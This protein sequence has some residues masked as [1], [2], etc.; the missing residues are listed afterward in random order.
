MLLFFFGDGGGGGGRLRPFY[1]AERNYFSN[2]GRESHKE[3]FSEII[4]KT[5]HWSTRCRFKIFF[6]FLG[7]GGHF[8]QRNKT[9]LAILSE[10]HPRN[11]SV[12][13][14]CNRA[15]VCLFFILFSSGD[16]FVQ[17]SETILAILVEGYPK[18]NL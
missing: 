12:K 3:H 15:I 7:S 6:L 17:R 14:F 5:G 13:L 9:I 16:H 4:L 10:G 8:V 18:K 2:G 11:I 1:L